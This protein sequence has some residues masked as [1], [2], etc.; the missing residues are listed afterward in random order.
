LKREEWFLLFLVLST[1]NRGGQSSSSS[2]SS[3]PLPIA[4]FPVPGVTSY[5]DTFGKPWG[6]GRTHEGIDIFAPEGSP[7]LAVA[8]G[9]VRMFEG[10]RGGKE[11]TLTLP[12]GTWFL[13][14]HLHDYAKLVPGG[15]VKAGDLLGH[16]GETGNALRKGAHVHF[17]V[18]P[19]GGP[20]AD[21]Y[22]ALKSVS[23]AE[24]AATSSPRV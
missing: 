3:S 6:P 5:A 2:S 9:V 10:P 13:Y 14:S 15:K 22:A 8:D 7:V 17:E 4:R 20:A 19:R 16:V 21:P 12:D 18:H 24:A 1:G 23:G 11:V